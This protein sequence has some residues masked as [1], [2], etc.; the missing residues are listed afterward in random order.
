MRSKLEQSNARAGKAPP[1]GVRRTELP[2]TLQD[3]VRAGVDRRGVLET[4]EPFAPPLESLSAPAKVMT[5]WERDQV[6]APGAFMATGLVARREQRRAQLRRRD[7]RQAG[8]V[9]SAA[10]DIRE[11]RRA[12]ARGAHSNDVRRAGRRGSAGEARAKARRSWQL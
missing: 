10:E 5:A 2:W 12:V 3:E 7:V 6:N 8:A 9:A 4:T 1:P 11:T